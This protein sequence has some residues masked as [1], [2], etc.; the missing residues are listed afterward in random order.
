MAKKP[1]PQRVAAA[2]RAVNV[3]GRSLRD[4]AEE[5]G[6]S[7]VTVLRWVNAAKAATKPSK[8]KAKASKPPAEPSPW[9]GLT[10][11]L[12]ERED[13]PETAPV[14]TELP[15]DATLLEQVMALQRDILDTAR[16]AKSVGNVKAAQAALASAGLLSNTI[17]RIKKSEAEGA[18][19][20]KISRATIDETAAQ[21]RERLA[22][23]RSRPLC[24][25]SCSRKLSIEYAYEGRTK[26][27]VI[28]KLEA[29]D[30]RSER[31]ALI[32]RLHEVEAAL[33]KEVA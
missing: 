7:Y 32:A 21:L 19:V 13:Q 25:A 9:T 4:V 12:A 5:Y 11:S 26:P 28:Q 33:E 17:A 15:E 23:M 24:C 22:T 2:V 20:L 16:Q 27:D 3:A 6:T 29:E 14:S 10:K 8:P 30:L 18:D 31:A 1:S